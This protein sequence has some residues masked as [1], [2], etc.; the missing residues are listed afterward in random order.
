[1]STIITGSNIT[2]PTEDTNS[3]KSTIDTHTGQIATKAEQLYVDN[4]PSGFK[5]LIINGGFDIWQRGT[6]FTNVGTGYTVDRFRNTNYGGALP[7]ITKVAGTGNLNN[8]LRIT[9]IDG[10]SGQVVEFDTTIEGG[11]LPNSGNLTISFYIRGNK[12][13][14]VST[15]RIINGL[16][17]TTNTGR[18]DVSITTSWTRVTKTVTAVAAND[19]QFYRVFVLDGSFGTY[20]N[21]LT[22]WIEITGIQLEEGSVATPFEQRPYGLE[23]SLCQRYYET[24][25]GSL[26]LLSRYGD[27]NQG[28]TFQF[29]NKKRVVPRCTISGGVSASINSISEYIIEVWGSNSNGTNSISS[30]TA[31]AELY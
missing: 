29:N 21:S 18:S 4:K 1:M 24:K 26:L 11:N 20:M 6:S 15:G 27:T 12:D 14:V 17:G 23:L 16:S 22:D 7:T 5:N 10:S 9:N 25:I 28:C 30:Y 2:T 31:D 8:A 19:S 3:M 13:G